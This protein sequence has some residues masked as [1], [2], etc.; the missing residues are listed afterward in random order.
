MGVKDR[1][2]ARLLTRFPSLMK[3]AVERAAAAGVHVEGVPWTPVEKKLSESTVAL[4]TTAGVHLKSQTPFDMDDKLGDASFRALPSDTPI[5]EYAITHDYYD[6][7]DADTD[8]NIVFPIERLR[9]FQSSGATGGLADTNYG[10]MGHIDG[11][12]IERLTKE[13]A[14]EVASRLRAAQV[15]V[16]LLTPG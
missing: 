13:T 2:L 4:V 5:E 12:Y 6:H 16:V 11:A 14:P 3:R 8:L 15:D 1:I 10:F 7:R 9:E